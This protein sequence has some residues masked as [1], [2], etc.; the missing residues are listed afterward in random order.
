MPIYEYQCKNCKHQLEAF[1]K[2]SEMPLT[3][4]PSCHQPTL[5]KLVSAAGFQLKGS[6]WYATDYRSNKTNNEE[7]GS[8]STSASGTT[9][10]TKPK[11][12]SS[13]ND[14]SAGS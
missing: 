2:I 8:S 4:C 11:G 10:E 3:D 12:S 13:S 9:T 5:Q 6:G 14:Q 1:Q 7:G